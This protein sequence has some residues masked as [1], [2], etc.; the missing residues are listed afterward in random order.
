MTD[1]ASLADY[2]RFQLAGLNSK[3]KHHLFEDLCHQFARLGISPNF[4]PA[5]G[6]VSAGG[7]QG[8]DSETFIS[9]VPSS[10]AVGTPW[11]FSDGR[12]AV[13]ACSLE[14]K[15]K[16]KIES[17]VRK[18]CEN[19]LRPKS[20]YFFPTKIFRSLFVTNCKSGQTR[21]LA[22]ILKYST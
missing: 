3:N 22:S 15:I 8:R 10:I 20:I 9:A 21:L 4:L 18:I 19:G 12:L 17:D 6:P 11:S 13:L 2:I 14:K 1:L 7:D 16:G 5:T